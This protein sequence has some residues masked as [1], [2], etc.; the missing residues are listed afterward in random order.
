MISSTTTYRNSIKAHIADAIQAVDFTKT[1]REDADSLRDAI[2]EAG[3]TLALS[4]DS[5]IDMMQFISDV[6]SELEVCDLDFSKCK[7]HKEAMFIEFTAYMNELV[8]E[9]LIEYVQEL[10]ELAERL[11]E[12]ACAEFGD[13]EDIVFAISNPLDAIPHDAELTHAC[14]GG[15]VVDYSMWVSEQTIATYINGLYVIATA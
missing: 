4:F 14:D 15:K 12:A 13:V 11:E 8:E 5:N 9:V 1:D 2:Q 7:N 3:V 10:V 6:E